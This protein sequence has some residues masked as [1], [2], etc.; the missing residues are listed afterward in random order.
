MNNAKLVWGWAGVAVVVV[1]AAFLL[2]GGSFWSRPGGGGY[3]NPSVS[4]VY[5]PQGQ[6]APQFPKELIL[7][8]AAAVSGSYSMNYNANINQYTAIWTSSSSMASLFTKYETYF[9]GNGWTI[10]NETTQYAALRAIYAK[11]AA[12]AAVNVAIV[13]R[14]KGS[15]VTISYLGK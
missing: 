7:D 8:P 5:A 6:L 13:Q 11:N 3:Q 1:A 9:K 2:W 14:D 4:P 10:T 12:G 15:Q